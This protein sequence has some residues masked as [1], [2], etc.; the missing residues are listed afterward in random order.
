MSPLVT[1]LSLRQAP[2]GPK[3]PT[4][5]NDTV[6]FLQNHKNKEIWREKAIPCYILALKRL[7]EKIRATT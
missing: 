3:V 5:E 4:G 2:L 7:S 6:P 1:L